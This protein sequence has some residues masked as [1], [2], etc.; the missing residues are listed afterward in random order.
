MKIPHVSKGW[1]IT[2]RLHYA[3]MYAS[4]VGQIQQR[5]GKGGYLGDGWAPNWNDVARHLVQISAD[6]LQ[7]LGAHNAVDQVNAVQQGWHGR[8]K[9][10]KIV[11]QSLHKTPDVHTLQ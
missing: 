2:F 11:C 7:R 1:T 9:G 3:L 8:S 4:G 6:K 10:A 5:G